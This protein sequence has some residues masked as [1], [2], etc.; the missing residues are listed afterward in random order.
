MILLSEKDQKNPKL[1]RK[2]RDYVQKLL[3]E[4]FVQ[5]S[6]SSQEWISSEFQA[7]HIAILEEELQEIDTKLRKYKVAP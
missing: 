5:C 3:D 7:G 1:L 4:G 2:R 6:P